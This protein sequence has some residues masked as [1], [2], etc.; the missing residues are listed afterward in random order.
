[1][2]TRITTGKVRLS[3]P[4]LF[5]PHAIGESDPKYS[6]MLLI[7][8]G[9]TATMTAMR[10]AEKEA[11]EIGKSSKFNGK[12]PSNLASIIKDGDEDGTAEDYPERAGHYYCTVSSNPQYKPGVVD[13]RV[14]E[15]VDQSEVY[16][17][18]YAKVSLTAFPYNTNGNK[19][20]SFGLNNVQILGGGDSLAGGK[21]ADEE[22]SVVEDEGGEDLL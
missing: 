22:F 3:F 14:Q 18:V 10:E 7:P 1:M 2:A 11:A 5:A 21:R 8:K 13:R 16:S 15:I 4:H 12:I 19:G 6:V 17:G 20:I 9:D